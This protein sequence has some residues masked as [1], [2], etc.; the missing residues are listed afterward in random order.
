MPTVRGSRASEYSGKKERRDLGRRAFPGR[1]AIWL[2]MGHLA[3]AITSKRFERTDKKNPS[4]LPVD[5]CR[6]MT[7]SQPSVAENIIFGSANGFIEVL[8]R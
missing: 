6:R 3:L 7:A 2:F 5:G 8:L 1:D 4:I